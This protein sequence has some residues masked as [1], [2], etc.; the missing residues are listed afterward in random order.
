MQ[1]NI[2]QLIK[3]IEADEVNIKSL[4]SQ[5]E[6]ERVRMQDAYNAGDEARGKFSET[7]VHKNELRINELQGE[8][9]NL[10]NLKADAEAR[11]AS[12]EQERTNLVTEHEQRLVQLDTEISR[13]KGGMTAL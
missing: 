6:I 2:R 1:D 12:L 7:Q 9:S 3:Q 5:T 13:L 4:E 8:L 10:Q 11:L